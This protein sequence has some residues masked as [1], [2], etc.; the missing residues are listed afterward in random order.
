MKPYSNK[1]GKCA[2]VCATHNVGDQAWFVSEY[3]DIVHVTSPDPETSRFQ[4]FPY[5]VC[6]LAYSSTW[7][8]SP[9][10]AMLLLRGQRSYLSRPPTGRPPLPLHGAGRQETMCFNIP[11]FPISW[12]EPAVGA[13]IRT[14]AG[15][16]E[17]SERVLWETLEWWRLHGGGLEG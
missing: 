1:H 6:R 5:L 10:N 8:D 15:N 16:T 17:R 4:R 13:A 9:K 3:T 14:M 11:P 7:M 2:V 12:E